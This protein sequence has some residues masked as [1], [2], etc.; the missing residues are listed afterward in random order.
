MKFTRQYLLVLC[1][2]LSVSCSQDKGAAPAHPAVA[3]VVA[4][5]LP[6]VD[7]IKHGLNNAEGRYS[8]LADI[9]TENVAGLSLAWFFDYPTNR[10]METTPLERDGV[11]YSTGSWSMVYAHDAVSGKLLWLYDPEVPRDW[12]LHACC[13]VVNRGVALQ[14]NIVVFGTIDGRLVSLDASTGKL[15]WEVQTTDTSLP[16]TITGAPRIVN[17]RAIIGNG[18]AEYGV[19]GYISAYNIDDGKMAWRF[20]TVPGNPEKPFERPAMERAAKTWGGGPWWEIGGGGTVWDS[21]AYDEALNLLYI[22]VGN[23]APWNREIRSPDGGDNLYLSSIVALNPDDGSYVWHYQTTPGDSWD[24]TAT[25]HMILADIEIDGVE[26]QVIMQAPKNGFFYVLDRKTGE[27]I[28]A[29]AYG[30]ATWASHIDPKTGRPIEADG[31]RY[32]DNPAP[33]FPAPYGAHNWH[34]MSYNPDTGLVYIPAQ[35]IPHVYAQDENFVHNPGFW[36]TGTDARAALLPSDPVERQAVV[37]MVKGHITAWDPV[38]QKERWRVT[39]EGPWNGGM[40]STAGNLLF[41]GNAE[42]QLVAYSADRGEPLWQFDAQTG[43]VAPPMTFRLNGEQYIAV[44]AG[45]GGTYALTAGDDDNSGPKPNYSRLLVFKLGGQASLPAAPERPA[46]LVFTPPKL[47]ATPEQVAEGLRLFHTYCFV[48]HGADAIAGGTPP[49][50]RAISPETRASWDAIVLGGMHWQKGMVGF[51]KVLSK[52]DSD[53][54][55]SYVTERA[56]FALEKD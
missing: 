26:R 2:I 8:E 17:N 19:R 6:D 45:W 48:C 41:Q 36:N 34:P 1:A 29:Q 47:D 13:D 53:N 32:E 38:A 15:R 5:T 31:V 37:D 46:K 16:Y 49:D 25:Q 40:L 56:H 7:W 43:I 18:G 39:H 28:S 44:A 3:P 52:D 35:D 27:F 9:N 14:D 22:G 42:G 20:Y 33:I 10:G 11:I 51:S 50:L 21:M 30:L 4:E 55:L 23:G 54:I 24:Y 12:A